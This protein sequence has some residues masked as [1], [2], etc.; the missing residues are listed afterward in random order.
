MKK[1]LAPLVVCL[2]AFFLMGGC[3]TLKSY[4]TPENARSAAALVCSN[5]ITFAASDA[6]RVE[7]ANYVYAVAHAVR[8]LS[9]GKVP[10]PA[11]L[12]AAIQ[13][14]TPKAD[15]WVQLQS[16]ISIIY[17]GLYSKLNGNPRLAAQYLEAIAA[18]CEDAASSFLPP[19]PKTS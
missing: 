17:G 13:V 7:T 15:K 6:D 18:G 2:S 1:I 10:T 4:A 8:T 5:T 3:E 16:G 14:F 9:G 19:P 12:R 11:E